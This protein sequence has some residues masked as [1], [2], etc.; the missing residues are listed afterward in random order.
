MH[1][2]KFSGYSFSWSFIKCEEEFGMLRQ[3]KKES[4]DLL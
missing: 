4:S 3:P 2:I 1:N